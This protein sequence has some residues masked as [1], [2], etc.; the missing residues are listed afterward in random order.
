MTLDKHTLVNEYDSADSA[1]NFRRQVEQEYRAEI[2]QLHGENDSKSIQ[3]TELRAEVAALRTELKTYKEANHDTLTAA[4]M[5]VHAGLVFRWI[6]I[7]LVGITSA[8]GGMSFVFELFKKWTH[9]S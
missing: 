7:A 9:S 1:R 5:I 3:L 8:I 4:K 6:I 2:R